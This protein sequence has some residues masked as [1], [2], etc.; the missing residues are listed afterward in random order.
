MD[1]PIFGLIPSLK[2]LVPSKTFVTE[3]RF[4]QLCKQGG[5]PAAIVAAIINNESSWRSLTRY[6]PVINVN[7]AMFKRLLTESGTTVPLLAELTANALVSRNAVTKSIPGEDSFLREQRNR[8]VQAA[9]NYIRYPEGA[10]SSLAIGMGQI[11]GSNHPI[12]GAVSPLALL[13]AAWE[14][15]SQVRHILSFLNQPVF[16]QAIK[17]LD[18]EE[19][20]ARYAGPKWLSYYPDWA[21]DVRRYANF[22]NNRGYSLKTTK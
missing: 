9:A 13:T 6:G 7:P 16:Q 18:F 1:N 8:W 20:A 4:Q 12:I 3:A 5:V 19:L 11:L 17:D 2:S 15:E 21:K 10:L 22:Y 14:P